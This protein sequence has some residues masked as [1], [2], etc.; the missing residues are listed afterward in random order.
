MMLHHSVTIA[1]YG[2]SYLCNLTTIGAVIMFLHDWA[3][4]FSA[5]AR[6]FSE[7]RFKLMATVNVVLLA[8]TWLYSRLI[9]FPQVLYWGLFKLD[10]II[11]GS[12]QT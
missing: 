8:L 12:S 4:I 9:V 6:A 5:Y 10:L 3:D 7:T 11:D 2:L 1:L